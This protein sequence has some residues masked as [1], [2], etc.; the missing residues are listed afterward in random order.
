MREICVHV[1]KLL[2]CMCVIV[3]RGHPRSYS[4]WNSKVQWVRIITSA[5]NFMLYKTRT[6]F[7][8]LRYS[9]VFEA[10]V[11]VYQ[12]P[13]GFYPPFPGRRGSVGRGIWRW[14]WRRVLHHGPQARGVDASI[15]SVWQSGQS[16]GRQVTQTWH[17][18]CLYRKHVLRCS[19]RHRI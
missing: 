1:Y 11:I 2:I 19:C 15:V 8:I 7:N 14:Q 10:Y 12:L 17:C 13:C 6:V 18:M 16:R 3:L 5:C 4:V 9:S